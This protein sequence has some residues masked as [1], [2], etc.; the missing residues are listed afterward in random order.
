MKG[1]FCMFDEGKSP[2]AQCNGEF[3]NGKNCDAWRQWFW[4]QWR[5][6]CAELLRRAAERGEK[7]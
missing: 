7:A 1:A 3:C 6:Q 5:L 4:P 2:C